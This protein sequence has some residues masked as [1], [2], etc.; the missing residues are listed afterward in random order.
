MQNTQEE[1]PLP[2]TEVIIKSIDEKICR[3]GTLDEKITYLSNKMMILDQKVDKLLE[4]AE[5]LLKM[6]L[7][8]N[9]MLTSNVSIE[10]EEKKNV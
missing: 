9:V 1:N 5:F 2:P 3:M 6:S 4:K 10:E 8:T 7:V